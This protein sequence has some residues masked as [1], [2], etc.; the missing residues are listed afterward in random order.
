MSPSP[1]ADKSHVFSKNIKFSLS[2]ATPLKYHLSNKKAVEYPSVL[3][4][5]YGNIQYF[6]SPGF[7]FT[8]S[9]PGFA[10]SL[11]PFPWPHGWGGTVTLAT[12]PA[13]FP[14]RLML[15]LAPTRRF[16]CFVFHLEPL[17][18]AAISLSHTHMTMQTHE[19]KQLEAMTEDAQKKQTFR[20]RSHGTA[21]R[22]TGRETVWKPMRFIRRRILI[23]L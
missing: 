9:C 7:Y 10:L 14:H 5:L 16:G 13:P 21:R 11:F 20:K 8:Q 3:V 17:L 19:Q 12:P 6:S 1:A 2:T 23:H 15:H 4:I 18:F 22:E